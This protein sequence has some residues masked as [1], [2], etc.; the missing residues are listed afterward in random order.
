MT[1]YYTHLLADSLYY[2]FNRTS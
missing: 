1:I 2:T